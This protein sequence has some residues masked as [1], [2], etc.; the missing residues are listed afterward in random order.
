MGF[1]YTQQKRFEEAL[2]L[3]KSSLICCQRILGS[4]HI[5]T[6]EV[7]LEIANLYMKMDQNKDEAMNFYEKAYGIFDIMK[8]TH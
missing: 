7:Y 3:Y 4:N 2:D 5:Q 1:Y 8:Y 6:A